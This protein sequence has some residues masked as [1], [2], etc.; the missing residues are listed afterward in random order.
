MR[1]GKVGCVMGAYNR[2]ND[3]ACCSSPFLLGT[4]LRQRW[5]FQGYVV[6]DCGA[7]RDISNGHHL[8]KTSIGGGGARRE[9]RLRPGMRQRLQ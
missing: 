2:V 9:G 7:I 6:S 3:E 8:V 1:E 4:V 5:G